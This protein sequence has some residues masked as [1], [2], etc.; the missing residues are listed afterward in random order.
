[1]D[2]LDNVLRIAT[3]DLEPA[4]RVP[5]APPPRPPFPARSAAATPHPPAHRT[6]A[7][8]LLKTDTEGWD[9]VALAGAPATLAATRMV[10][11]ECH[12][13]MATEGGPRTTHAQAGALL[14]AAG[15]ESYKLSA[16]A[17]LRFDGEWYNQR[18]DKG[19]WMG[20]HN[21]LAVR[22]NDPVRRKLLSRLNGLP[23][24]AAPWGLADM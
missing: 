15:F 5:P 12:M 4:L 1:M 14:A 9:V 3:Q 24:C 13:K 10:L 7:V 2:T 16:H 6:Y 19:R 22:R 21:C 23:A 20:W 18:L 8:D 11:W 17:L